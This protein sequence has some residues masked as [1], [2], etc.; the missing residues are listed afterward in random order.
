[1][2][3][4][5]SDGGA[6]LLSPLPAA[7]SVAVNILLDTHCIL[8]RADILDHAAEHI[9]QIM[10][11]KLRALD[12]AAAMIARAE[13]HAERARRPLLGREMPKA[14]LVK[15]ALPIITDHQQRS[16][17]AKASISQSSISASA[18]AE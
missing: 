1:M 2:R 6:C 7:E 8:A 10:R 4:R 16:P 15:P 12:E 5:R 11:D 18:Q 17:P 3:H 9:R 13:T 14:L